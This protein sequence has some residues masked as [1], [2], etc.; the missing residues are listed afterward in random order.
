MEEMK[1]LIPYILA[2]YDKEIVKKICNKYG[3]E[4]MTALKLFLKSQTYQMLADIDLQMWDFS[5]IG[6]FDIWECEQVTGTLQNSLY[7]RRA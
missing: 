1:E 6:I 3:F 5:P 7:L 2:Y 4:P